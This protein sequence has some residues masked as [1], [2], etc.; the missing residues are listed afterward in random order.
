M[1]TQ[2]LKAF[3]LGLLVGVIGTLVVNAAPAPSVTECA[4]VRLVVNDST[5][6]TCAR[7]EADAKEL[8]ALRAAA[9]DMGG[10]PVA[11]VR[12]V[13]ERD[14]LYL[15][16]ADVPTDTGE[17]HRVARLVDT[18]ADYTVTVHAEAPPYPAPL[19]L[20]YEVITPERSAE[21]GF[22]RHA[23][24]VY[25]TVTGR[26]IRATSAFYDIRPAPR[27]R[28]LALYGTAVAGATQTARGSVPTGLLG[29]S[30]Q[31]RTTEWQTALEAGLT[32]APSAAL[33]IQRKLF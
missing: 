7:L 21:I 5:T 6:A 29:L 30:L 28:P 23:S 13:V 32:P 16:A 12:I 2:A 3:A 22:V 19:R 14:T 9:K 17:G 1:S 25:A 26:G 24:G 18:T 8:A 27:E 20:G 11:G 31:Y 33:R 4:A 15:P 10:T